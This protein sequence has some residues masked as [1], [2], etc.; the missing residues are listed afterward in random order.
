MSLNESVTCWIEGLRKGSPQSAQ[1]LWDRYFQQLVRLAG[2]KLPQSVK[3]TFDEEDVALSA[4]D[5]LC[6]GVRTERFPRIDDRDNLWSLLVVITARKVSHQLRDATRAKR[7]GGLVRGESALEQADH[8]NNSPAINQ[9]I[10]RDPTAEFALQVHEQSQRLLELL[11]DEDMRRLAV[12]KMEGYTNEEAASHL[13]CGLRTVERRLA[14]IRKIW[15]VQADHQA[16][17]Q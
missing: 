2:H 16:E 8:S 6:R 1:Q 15:T 12:L 3:R 9:I 11:A 5:S 13:G 14:L 7:G 10:G 17:S 4:F